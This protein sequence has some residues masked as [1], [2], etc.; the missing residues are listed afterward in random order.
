MGDPKKTRKK[1]STPSHP[2]QKARIEEETELTKSYAL[3]N[4]KE[5]WK[6]GSILKR[7]KKQAKKLGSLD[8]KQAEKEKEQLL[9]RL[10]AMNLLK[11]EDNLE[12]ILILNPKDIMERRLQTIVVKKGFARSMKQARQFITHGHVGIG[13]KIITSPSYIV[14]QSEEASIK[15]KENSALSNSDHPE[16]K[17]AKPVESA[18][19]KKEE[20]SKQSSETSEKPS[21]SKSSSDKPDKKKAKAKK[22]EKK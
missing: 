2:W 17:I 3:K 7:F 19:E 9:K 16:R 22:S 15:F 1:Y 14:L 13:N 20:V 21:P 8:S 10:K 6:M 4:K 5:I 12:T 18:K 11:E